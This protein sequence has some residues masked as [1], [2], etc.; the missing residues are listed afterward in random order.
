[1]DQRPH[2]FDLPASPFT[3]DHV[4]FAHLVEALSCGVV[5]THPTKPDNPIVF[6]NQA[7]C[8]MTGY[9]AADVIGRDCNLLQ[10]PDTDQAVT[11]EIRVALDAGHGIRRTVLNYRK[12]GETFWNDLNIDPLRNPGG[13]VIGY[14]GIQNDVTALK[15]AELS[16]S[17]LDIRLSGILENVRGYILSRV[18]KADEKIKYSYISK[19]F[20][21]LVG[22]PESSPSDTNFLSFV[23]PLDRDRVEN[24]IRKSAIDLS[25]VLIEA[26]LQAPGQPEHWVRSWSSV[27]REKNGDTVWDGFGIEITAERRAEE[28][29]IYITYH[30]PLT[31][32]PNRAR[33]EAA[34]EDALHDETRH[35]I[36]SA[37]YFIDISA[38]HEA[39]ETFGAESGDLII[40]ETAERLQQIAGP[41]AMVARIGG[42][43]FAVLIS[44]VAIR[45]T[46]NQ[47]A[48]S[49][50]NGLSRPI[51]LH[52]DGHAMRRRADPAFHSTCNIEVC[53]GIADFPRS[54]EE[55][56]AV[57]FDDSVSE[58]LKRCDVALNEAKRLGRGRYC[59]YTPEIDDKV[60]NRMELRQSLHLAVTRNEFV[61]HYQPI[62]DLRSG[63]I[64]AAEALVR[65]NHPRL[66]MQ[67][68]ERFIPFAEES[69]LIVPL[70]AWVMETS[71]RQIA[72]WRKTFGLGKVAVNVSVRQITEPGFLETVQNL[73]RETGT[74][75]EMIDLELT[76]GML[77][78]FSPEMRE[79][80]SALRRLGFGISID[81]F[82]TGYSSLKY[83]SAMPVDKI[84]I[85]RSFVRLMMH[86]ASD[87]SII[88]AVI[89]LGQNLNLDIVAEGVETLEQQRFLVSQGCKLGQGYLFS[90][91]VPADDFAALL[92]QNK[93]LKFGL[94]A[95]M[96]L[97][98]NHQED[99]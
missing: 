12:S 8:R 64:V 17:E 51:Q 11:A 95:A 68:P 7:F 80:M 37:L 46:A 82:G 43:E 40:R 25:P 93:L 1:M 6:V 65:W 42:D 66:G 5:I 18:M 30:D 99:G 45:E 53:V 48:E 63:A 84:K 47:I 88:K 89:L 31:N 79:Q 59:Q 23:S 26:R 10:G 78:D 15:I 33:L 72:P 20:F 27:R 98:I 71:M 35:E 14:I 54:S 49:I 85:D 75:A 94:E 58:Y 16:R 96:P 52:L 57:A 4:S 62:V 86:G 32:L 28:Q 73:L 44:G 77:I 56:P 19:S 29:L 41:G 69:G 74:P 22:V 83:L 34:V 70:G 24:A 13:E 55:I 38:F 2:D 50:C 67:P 76:E 92:E 90:K 3:H 36:S 97:N 39:N 9:D 91:P 81:D 61:L 21:Q 60:R 87:A